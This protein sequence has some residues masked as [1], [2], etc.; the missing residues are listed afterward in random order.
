MSAS[1]MREHGCWLFAASAKYSAENIR[2]S[3]GDFSK[4]NNIGKYAARLG[5]SLSSSIETFQ[6]IFKK[7]SKYFLNQIQQFYFLRL[8]IFQLFQILWIALAMVTTSRTVS[9]K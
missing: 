9:A 5:Q 6:V 2:A 3:L 1:Q 7:N 4:I 8:R